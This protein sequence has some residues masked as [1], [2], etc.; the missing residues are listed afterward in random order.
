MHLAL[1]M[2]GLGGRQL[3]HRLR[4]TGYGTTRLFERF[5]PRTL[6][7]QDLGAMHQA[8]SRET[9]QVGLLLAPPR[10]GRC[11]FAGAAQVVRLLTAEDHPAV[12]H[13]ADDRRQLARGDRQHRLV[14]QSETLRDPSEPDV[15]DALRLHGE[16]EQIRIAEA[17]ADLR[18]VGC[19][20]GCGLVVTAGLVLK[21][22]RK[23]Q[24]APFHA[25]APL[26]LDQPLRA[27][28]PSG[29]AALLTSCGESHA[30]P[31][32]APSRAE[33]LAGVEVEVI[34]TLKA[35]Q[36]VAATEHVGRR[37]QQL[38]VVRPE[39]RRPVGERQG[40][41][42]FSPRPACIRSAAVF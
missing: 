4:A 27:A 35:F 25:V 15:Q 39:R 12:D 10:Q 36:V 17:P 41:P 16:G 32:R 6:Q 2:N 29:R 26:T 34:R 31:E 11:P 20:G 22:E 7:L 23:Q 33:R 42:G 38:H 9:H 24:I 8:R 14:H 19:D 13:A 21:H 28:E 37:P 5:A 3:V 18:S 40:L 1:P 30:H